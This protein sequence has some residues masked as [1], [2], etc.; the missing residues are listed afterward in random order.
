MFKFLNHRVK[1]INTE[2]FLEDTHL[3]H[4]VN[5]GLGTAKDLVFIFILADL[6]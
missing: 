3:F 6:E 4:E 5:F 1:L 2:G